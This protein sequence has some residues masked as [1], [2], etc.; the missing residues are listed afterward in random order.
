MNFKNQIESSLASLNPRLVDVAKSVVSENVGIFVELENEYWHSTSRPVSSINEHLQ[1]TKE[2]KRKVAD[3][4][5]YLLATREMAD[6]QSLIDKCQEPESDKQKSLSLWLKL[7]DSG[8][9]RPQVSL[10]WRSLPDRTPRWSLDSVAWDIRRPDD[11]RDD[12]YVIHIPFDNHG[13]AQIDMHPQIVQ[14][15]H[16]LPVNISPFDLPYNPSPAPANPTSATPAP[17][18]SAQQPIDPLKNLPPELDNARAKEMFKAF[19]DAGFIEPQTDGHFK[20]TFSRRKYPISF[21]YFVTAAS[22]YLKL[23]KI[24]INGVG[25]YRRKPFE[26]LFGIYNTSKKMYSKLSSDNRNKINDI[27]KKLTSS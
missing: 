21:C 5:E 4:L 13:S 7:L 23:T 20:W 10:S 17:D 22:D 14:K 19:M 3:K 27:F 24:N 15:P 26:D 25:V 1:R 2:Y 9:V 8:A 12:K 18:L 11:W 16:P 6:V